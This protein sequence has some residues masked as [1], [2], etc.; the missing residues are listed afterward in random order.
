LLVW[1]SIKAEARLKE[2]ER[3]MSGSS[4]KSRESHKFQTFLYKISYPYG[5]SFAKFFFF[6]FFEYLLHFFWA[7]PVK[8]MINPN[9]SK[10]HIHP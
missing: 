2:R 1:Q 6:F 9:L 3:G 4:A 10:Q 8:K 7:L 5:G